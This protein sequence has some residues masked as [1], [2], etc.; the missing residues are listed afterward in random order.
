MN[1]K[2]DILPLSV[3]TVWLLPQCDTNPGS[4]VTYLQYTEYFLFACTIQVGK[5]R[6]GD[7]K[8]LGLLGMAGIQDRGGSQS[9]LLSCQPLF[10]LPPALQTVVSV[11]QDEQLHWVPFKVYRNNSCHVSATRRHNR[12]MKERTVEVISEISLSQAFFSTL[13]KT[14]PISKCN[15]DTQFHSNLLNVCHN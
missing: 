7:R 12:W 6:R 1:D 3:R 9:A 10:W 13:K 8:T 15:M 4:I 5:T 11:A 2:E 14:K